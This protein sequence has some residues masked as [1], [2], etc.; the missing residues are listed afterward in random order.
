MSVCKKLPIPE[1]YYE[2]EDVNGPLYHNKRGHCEVAGSQYCQQ[3][4]MDDPT[5]ECIEKHR[6]DPLDPRD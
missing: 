2:P 5:P 6:H 3:C 1:E 4:C